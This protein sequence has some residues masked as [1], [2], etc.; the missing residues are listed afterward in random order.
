MT[1]AKKALSLADQLKFAKLAAIAA[2]GSAE[3][4]EEDFDNWMSIRTKPDEGELAMYLAQYIA[5]A[6]P[7]PRPEFRLSYS[8]YADLTSFLPSKGG[9]STIV[10]LKR[11]EDND[12]MFGLEGDT[13]ITRFGKSQE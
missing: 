11:N 6:R 2:G 5:T 3:H 13:N 4:V 12:L 7:I 9:R 1:S 10:V 8:E